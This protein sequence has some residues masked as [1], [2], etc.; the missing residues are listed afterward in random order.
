MYIYVCQY[1]SI[2]E[3]YAGMKIAAYKGTCVNVYERH[4]NRRVYN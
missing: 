2:I 1:Q 4:R 3:M